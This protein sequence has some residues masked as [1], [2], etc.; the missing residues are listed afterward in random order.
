MNNIKAKEKNHPKVTVICSIHNRQNYIRQCVDSILNQSL[1]NLEVILVDNGCS[2]LCPQIIEEYALADSRVVTLHNG[3]DSTYGHALNQAI[4]LA[5]GDYIGIVESDDFISPYMYEKLYTKITE[6]DADVCFAGFWVHI[7]AVDNSDNPHNKKIFAFSNDKKNFTI[8]DY[9]LLLTAHPCIWCKLY[10]SS[11]LKKI[12]FDEK[13]KFIDSKFIVDV[14]CSAKKMISIKEPVYYYRFDNPDASN[15]NSQ[16][17]MSLSVF[18]DDCEK[19]RQS[20]IDRGYY[21]KLKAE[22]YSFVAM[23]TYRFY[24]NIDEKYKKEYFK[25]WSLFIRMLANDK[26]YDF[27]YLDEDRK[28]FFKAGMLGNFDALAYDSFEEKKL[29]GITVYTKKTLKESN[30]TIFLFGLLSYIS[31]EN[32]NMFMLFGLCFY[33][34][35]KNKKS[36]FVDNENKLTKSDFVKLERCV[37]DLKR[38]ILEIKKRQGLGFRFSYMTSSNMSAIALHKGV[39]EKYRNSFFSKDVVIVGCGPTSNNYKPIKGAIHIGVN[40][41]FRNK[42]VKLD[43][44]FAQDQFPEGMYEINA[45][46]CV[47]FYGWLPNERAREVRKVVHRIHPC[48]FNINN[49]SK[50]ILEDYVKGHWAVDL[51]LEPFGDFQGCIFSA[52]QFACF[53][54]PKNIYLV[55]CDCSS[56]I[57]PTLQVASSNVAY[58]IQSWKSFK[59]FIEE[60][61]PEINVISINPVGLKGLFKDVYSI[62]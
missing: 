21:E 31:N 34:K 30:Q 47:K 3:T 41:A 56:S 5:L 35:T 45:Y 46:D 60:I 39:F 58:Q 18:I 10:K 27:K 6:F 38:E 32:E 42:N 28:R 19:A 59:D 44:L 55:G 4:E 1:K 33:K 57:N 52:L 53:G 49:V 11:F 23:A 29:F 62:K 17:D 16:K 9:P 13:G 48:N 7:G 25:K 2:D 22:F 50:Y 8:E 20:L 26:S 36:L 24:C 37:L 43:Y 14:L 40:R 61:Y 15:S 51:T 54:H 12:K